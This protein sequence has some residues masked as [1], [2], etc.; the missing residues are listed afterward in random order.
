M[1][2]RN[3][4]TLGGAAAFLSICF[5]AAI[6]LRAAPYE[7]PA[8]DRKWTDLSARP[9]KFLGSNTLAGAEAIGHD[10]A[11]W[12]EVKI[13]HT[14]NT[15]ANRTAYSNA[16]YRTRFEG[17]S[18][19]TVGGRR[20]Y[21]YFG[22]A[23]ANADVYLN[24]TP[25]GRHVGG[26]TAFL[27][28]ATAARRD[29]EN[30]LA[31]KVDNATFPGLPSNGNGWV[32]YGG[33]TRKV[34][35][36]VTHP[37]SI[38]PTDFASSGV[39][40][41]QQQVSA[42][43]AGLSVR[44]M[45]RN[46]SGSDKTFVVHVAVC[47]SQNNVVI[48]LRDSVSVPAAS[49]A[50]LVFQGSLANPKLWSLGSPYLYRIYAELHVDGV[51][52]DLV[53][54]R[55]GFRSYQLTPASFSMN[56]KQELLRGAGLHAEN[57]AAFAAL[58]SLAIRRQFDVAE[59]MG[60]NFVRLVHYPHSPAA[61]ALADERGLAVLTE[62]GLYQNSASVGSQA[63]DDNTREM[64]KQNFNRPSILWWAAGNEDYYAGNVSRFAA[65]IRAAD[66][67]RP[68]VYASSGQN[69]TGVD[70]IFQNIYQGWYTGAIKDFPA[71]QHWISE[72]GAGGVIASHQ[73]YKSSNFKVGTFEPEEY[74]SLVLE[75]KF[76]Y[77]FHDKPS[78]VPLYAHWLLF[79]V[80]DT[81][82]KGLN[83]KGLLTAA[84]FPKDGYYLWKAKARPD[85]PL[86]RINGKHWVLRTGIRDVKVYSNRPSITLTVNGTSAGSKA[87]GAYVHPSTGGVI[88]DV[89]LFD[90]VLQKG[91]NTVVASDGSGHADTAVLYF[92]GSAPMAPADT[93]EL[94]ADLVSVNPANPA[95]FLN[96]PLQNQ[97][98]VYYQGDGNADNTFDTLPAALA[99]ARWI[100]T[101][102]QSQT[103]T[104]LSFKVKQGAEVYVLVTKQAN[105]PTWV[106]AAGLAHTAITGQ[107]RDNDMNLVEFE[108]FGNSFPAGS[109]V[110]V[111]GS[112]VDFVVLVKPSGATPIRN[113]ADGAPAS[114]FLSYLSAGRHVVVPRVPGAILREIAVYA[115]SGKCVHRSFLGNEAKTMDIGAAAAEGVH[116]IR[117]RNISP[118]R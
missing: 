59:D 97:W 2:I 64:V 75:H 17:A 83:T 94:I 12:T 66:S 13:P 30:V 48:T 88:H 57:E 52:R 35:A 31:V 108:V 54:E 81:K 114:P 63:R 56:G 116:L 24:G 3:H 85:L 37:Y 117:V 103:P 104:G 47:D 89:F 16:W 100:A 20:F 21:L 65:V 23:N 91:R 51:V 105:A 33:L 46:A 29:G 72:S 68:V 92:A 36:L 28:D 22:A 9:W 80:S 1:K 32:H 82:Y 49:K 27:F 60:M 98:P 44:T 76:Q 7:P 39:Y 18:A 14:W 107:W 106:A 55:T 8:T 6:P 53:A 90:S 84:G 26:Y 69:P 71:G 113:V 34:M 4:G 77:L 118:Q 58:D 87:D 11:G 115:L 86:I 112:A 40:V 67:T 79:D 96:L 99:G 25:L 50:S 62:N 93:S 110:Q 95:Y 10:D 19:D 61:Y 43:Q 15:K 101:K 5:A 41:S 74:E 109:S 78:D 73:D 70:H 45:L 38:D 102:R 111:G 42:A